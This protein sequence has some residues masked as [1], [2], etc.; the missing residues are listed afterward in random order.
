MTARIGVALAA[1]GGLLLG[2][3]PARAEGIKWTPEFF[4]QLYGDV[5]YTYRFGAS[6]F[7]Q[8]RA[9]LRA[10]LIDVYGSVKFD[11]ANTS[12]SQVPTPY[13]Y[14]GLVP[15][16]GARVW[17]P[18]R[19][20]W[21]GVEVGHGVI[22]TRKGQ[23][24]LRVGGT[25]Y[26]DHDTP[27]AWRRET[28]AE[29]FFVDSTAPVQDVFGMLRHRQGWLFA[30]AVGGWFWG[31]GVG[32][33]NV[34]GRPTYAADNRVELGLGV[35]WRGFRGWT[36]APLMADTVAGVSLNVEARGGVA[37]RGDL[38][39]MPRAYVTPLFVL[40]GGF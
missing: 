40:A 38:G 34:S 2:A 1:L 5:T 8:Y 13:S 15:A 23:N 7:E 30:E 33:L 25:G 28:Y 37:Y 21:F 32:Q 19:T 10:G 35:G 14:S 4:H 17:I 26:W 9:G 22:G 11:G 18:G 6:T 27:H 3:A 16:A 24:E 36:D 29:A 20:A 12:A 31:Y 39:G